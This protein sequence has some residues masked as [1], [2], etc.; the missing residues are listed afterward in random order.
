MPAKQP[1]TRE[2]PLPAFDDGKY[3]AVQLYKKAEYAGRVF[4]PAHK[5]TVRGD[6]AKEIADS[7]YTAEETTEP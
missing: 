3:Y 6:V 2:K 4:A 1:I 5:L 7:V